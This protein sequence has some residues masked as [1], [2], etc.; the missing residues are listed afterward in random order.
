MLTKCELQTNV[1]SKTEHFI[2]NR[3][4]SN[5]T[6]KSWRKISKGIIFGNF[7]QKSKTN[8]AAFILFKELMHFDL[9]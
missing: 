7:I 2:M 8:T 4:R 6:R 9:S 1:E 5:R 3:K